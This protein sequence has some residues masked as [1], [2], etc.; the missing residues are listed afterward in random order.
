MNRI[1][2]ASREALSEE[3]REVEAMILRSRGTI[4]PLYAVLLN[5]PSLA[6]GWEALMTAIRQK[7]SLS[8]RLRELVIL[9]VAVLNGADYEFTAH[10]P[11]AIEAGISDD[12]IDWIRNGER[13][14]FA[15]TERTVLEYTDTMTRD[16]VVPDSLFGQVSALFE[17]RQRVDLTAT[18]AAYNMVSRFLAALHIG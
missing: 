6:R 12:E 4:T 2:P 15:G 10:L 7:S 1:D 13:G 17:P 14:G 3:A 16:I 11:H 18:I 8:A 5:S 9:R